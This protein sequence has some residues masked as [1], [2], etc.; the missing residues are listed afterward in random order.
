MLFNLIFKNC[1]EGNIQRNQNCENSKLYT[2]VSHYISL[3]HEIKDLVSLLHKRKWVTLL[4]L[5]SGS[6]LDRIN[7]KI[8]ASPKYYR[9]LFGL[10]YPANEKKNYY[11]EKKEY[12]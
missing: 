7:V 9:S 1:W 8:P 2:F 5:L 3:K 10:C 6:D 4:F 11:L 12:S